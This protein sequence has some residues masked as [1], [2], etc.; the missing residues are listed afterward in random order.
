MVDLAVPGPHWGTESIN[1]P[2]VTCSVCLFP[3]GVM[4][5]FLD[6]FH[7]PHHLSVCATAFLFFPLCTLHE[8]KKNYPGN[9]DQYLGKDKYIFKNFTPNAHLCKYLLFFHSYC[10]PVTFPRFH[11]HTK[12]MLLS[13]VIWTQTVADESV[14]FSCQNTAKAEKIPQM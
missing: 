3:S 7:K 10:F 9:K 11:T 5:P 1:L 6:A 14:V 2:H 13:A 4:Q 8:D 12:G